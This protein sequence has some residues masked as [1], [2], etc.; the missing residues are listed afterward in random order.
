MRCNNI[1]IPYRLLINKSLKK[2]GAYLFL[3]K[4]QF[5]SDALLPGAY[6][7]YDSVYDV[8]VCVDG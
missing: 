5:I 4:N 2:Q 7:F 3:E 6:S 8:D 1:Y